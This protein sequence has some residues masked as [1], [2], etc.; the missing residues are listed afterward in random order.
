MGKGSIFLIL[1]CTFFHVQSAV[2]IRFKLSSLSQVFRESVKESPLNPYDVVPTPSVGAGAGKDNLEEIR[3]NYLRQEASIQSFGILYLIFGAVIC[4][5]GCLIPFLVIVEPMDDISS[6]SIPG[7]FVGLALALLVAG[8][9]AGIIAVGLG[10]RRFK[11]W[12]KLPASICAVIGLFLS[13]IGTI[14]GVYILLSLNS[15]KGNYMF[16][17]E[18]QRVREATP[19]LKYRSGSMLIA[20][21]LIALVLLIGFGFLLII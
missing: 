9:G 8:I 10:M 12:A 20:L 4:L 16:S 17:E 2:L 18:Y 13:P 3:Q 1:N 7:L 6:D 5:I 14:I 11:N 19:H 15:E 21:V